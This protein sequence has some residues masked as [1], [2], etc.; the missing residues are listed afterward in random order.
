MGVWIFGSNDSRWKVG[1]SLTA[2]LNGLEKKLYVKEG[3]QYVKVTQNRVELVEKGVAQHLQT[4]YS[5]IV[6][7][8]RIANRNGSHSIAKKAIIESGHPSDG[9][10]WGFSLSPSATGTEIAFT[11]GQLHKG[12]LYLDEFDIFS[13]LSADLQIRAKGVLNRTDQIKVTEFLN[14]SGF[15]F[16]LKEAFWSPSDGNIKFFY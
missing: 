13:N 1:Y 12:G 6:L 3:E 16:D 2:R 8:N 7:D 4:N 9:I 11:S 14:N 10:F 15:K 5:D